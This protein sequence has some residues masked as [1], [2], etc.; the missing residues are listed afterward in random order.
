MSTLYEPAVRIEAKDPFETM[1]NTLKGAVEEILFYIPWKMPLHN[2]VTK[3]STMARSECSYFI[4]EAVRLSTEHLFDREPLPKN[5]EWGSYKKDGTLSCPV[6]DPFISAE[7]F[8]RRWAKMILASKAKN[9]KPDPDEHTLCQLMRLTDGRIH[10]HVHAVVAQ[11]HDSD[12]VH[13]KYLLDGLV[14]AGIIPED[15][16]TNVAGTT[17]SQAKLLPP[18]KRRPGKLL[19]TD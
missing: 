8:G 3:W 4:H 18:K 5:W 1:Q 15:D 2:H 7:W 9:P 16:A 19:E 11:L 13:T 14:K 10:L 6:Q 17:Q 12:A